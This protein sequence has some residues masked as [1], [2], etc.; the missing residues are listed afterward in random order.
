[1]EKGRRCCFFQTPIQIKE[2]IN[3]KLK[4]GKHNLYVEMKGNE[5]NCKI[6]TQKELIGTIKFNEKK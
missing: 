2:K 6:E 3:R 4:E 1:M 5:N